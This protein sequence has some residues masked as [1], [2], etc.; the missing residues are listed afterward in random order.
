MANEKGLYWLAVGV[1]ALVLVNGTAISHQHWLGRV[2]DRSISMVEQ[3]TGHAAAYLNLVE[4]QLAN[5]NGRC[6]RSQAMAA[7]MQARLA[8]IEVAMARQQAACARMEAAHAR[9]TA[10]REMRQF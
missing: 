7:R 4:V 5:N 6:V 1:V 8:N 10:L 3:A 2:E 9:V